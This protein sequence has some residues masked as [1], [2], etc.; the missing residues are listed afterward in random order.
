[1]HFSKSNSSSLH[2]MACS[3]VYN[4]CTLL[5][6]MV[7]NTKFQCLGTQNYL[8]TSDIYIAFHLWKSAWQ[9]TLSRACLEIFDYFSTLDEYR[10]I[11]DKAK[12]SRKFVLCRKIHRKYLNKHS[13]K[14]NAQLKYIIAC[15]YKYQMYINSY[16][17]LFICE[18]IGIDC[19][20]FAGFICVWLCVC[21]CVCVC[22]SV[23][24]CVCCVPVRMSVYVNVSVRMRMCVGVCAFAVCRRLSVA[25]ILRHEPAFSTFAD[26]HTHKHTHTG[27]KYVETYCEAEI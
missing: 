20:H 25:S 9:F 11:F 5:H 17:Y 1:M 14:W 4:K 3:N 24:V 15:L 19:M 23:C 16:C 18:I 13:T 6:A 12:M 27:E 8:C 26:T 2:V 10:D 21:V 7:C 22:V